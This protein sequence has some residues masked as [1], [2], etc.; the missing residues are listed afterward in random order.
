MSAVDRVQGLR[1]SSAA[2]PQDRRPREQR[3]RAGSR[4]ALRRQRD[5]HLEAAGLKRDDGY[6]VPPGFYR[7]PNVDAHLAEAARLSAILISTPS[8]ARQVVKE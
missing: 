1:R 6:V 7:T 4:E 3:T 5:E 8:G 2:G